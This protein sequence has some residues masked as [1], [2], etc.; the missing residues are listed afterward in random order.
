MSIFKN[1]VALLKNI[2]CIVDKMIRIL[3]VSF[4]LNIFNGIMIYEFVLKCIILSLTKRLIARMHKAKTF[5]R[6][7]YETVTPCLSVPILV[8]YET[9]RSCINKMY[10]RIFIVHLFYINYRKEKMERLR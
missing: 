4:T 3:K 1:L 10:Y 8:S 7:I 6:T 2:K 5:S 9:I